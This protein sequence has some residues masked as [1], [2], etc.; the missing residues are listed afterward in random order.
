MKIEQWEGITEEVKLHPKCF[1]PEGYIVLLNLL[2]E[3][4]TANGQNNRINE[5]FH[6]TIR[7]SALVTGIG[8]PTCTYVTLGGNVYAKETERRDMKRIFAR[9][10]F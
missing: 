3:I 4:M 6:I 9:H 1:G 10:N 7:K 5:R 8:T 2:K